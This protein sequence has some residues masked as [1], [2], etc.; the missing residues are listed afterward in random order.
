MFFILTLQNFLI[1]QNKPNNKQHHQNN[2]ILL[3]NQITK[4]FNG[5]S[6]GI[7]QK[8]KK[9]LFWNIFSTLLFLSNENIKENLKEKLTP[10][11]IS[12][13]LIMCNFPCKEQQQQ[14]PFLICANLTFCCC[15]EI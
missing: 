1:M 2:S 8:T 6:K 15:F 3:I 5:T 7:F 4:Q 12:N 10:L 14:Q 9:I 11:N 13:Y